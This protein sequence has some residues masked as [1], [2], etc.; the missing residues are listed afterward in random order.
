MLSFIRHDACSATF[1]PSSLP[2]ATSQP[3]SS[4]SAQPRLNQRPRNRRHH[5]HN[6]VCV[7]DS[8]ASLD[9]N[10]TDESLLHL[11]TPVSSTEAE[12][13][14]RWPHAGQRL[15]L[16]CYND[17]NMHVSRVSFTPCSRRGV[18]HASILE[19]ILSWPLQ[20]EVICFNS[21]TMQNSTT[22]T[23]SCRINLFSYTGPAHRQTRII[24]SKTRQHVRLIARLHRGRMMGLLPH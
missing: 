9:T 15:R 19:N 24:N 22:P 8:I 14:S 17:V 11:R 13:H 7:Q 16:P 12:L 1:S 6:R 23:C 21:P 18:E 2:W 3:A 5:P 4:A 10:T 20:G